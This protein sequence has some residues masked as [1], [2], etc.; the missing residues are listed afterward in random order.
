MSAKTREAGLHF[1]LER[2]NTIGHLNA[3]EHLGSVTKTQAFE[4]LC[5]FIFLSAPPSSETP[6]LVCNEIEMGKLLA[7]GPGLGLPLSFS[8][9]PLGKQAWDKGK[10]DDGQ[11]WDDQYMNRQEMGGIIDR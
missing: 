2:W 10:G 6:W 11:R 9:L 5:I 7:A 8:S 3:V 4:L 1:D